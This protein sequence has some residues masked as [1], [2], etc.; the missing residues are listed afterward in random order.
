[1]RLIYKCIRI[2]FIYI[3]INSPKRRRF[4]LGIGY[5]YIGLI[6]FVAFSC[7]TWA[8]NTKI[9][10]NQYIFKMLKFKEKLKQAK[11][12]K[13]RSNFFFKIIEIGSNRDPKNV[14]Y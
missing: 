2:L 3:Y 1:M 9:M 14:Q 5:V 7:S 4:G 12:N 6:G 11:N 13:N 8:K 10:L